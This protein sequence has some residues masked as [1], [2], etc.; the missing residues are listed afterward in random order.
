MARLDAVKRALP[1][2][3][4]KTMK[5]S[6]RLLWLALGLVLGA[7]AAAMFVGQGKLA[8]AANDRFEDYVMCTGA[9]AVSAK[10]PTDGV[11]LLD[12][13]SGKLLV[14]VIDRSAGKIVGWAEVDLTNVSG[15]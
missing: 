13:R 2:A 9:V 3:G 7:V 14:T 10:A 8:L 11:W 6:G 12:Y 15:I 5:D 1:G 4:E